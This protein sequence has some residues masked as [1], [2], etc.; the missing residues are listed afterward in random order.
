MIIATFSN[1]RV[2]YIAME[3]LGDAFATAY[4]AGSVM[5]FCLVS[6]SLFIL[7]IIIIIYYGMYVDESSPDYLD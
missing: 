2:S 5:G 4:R 6:I 1:Y 3:S 7:N